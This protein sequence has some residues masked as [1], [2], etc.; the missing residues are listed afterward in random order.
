MTMLAASKGI[1]A[2][3]V[4]GTAWALGFVAFTSDARADDA[5]SSR[6]VESID[7]LP[8]WSLRLTA[9]GGVP[10]PTVQQDLLHEEGYGGLRWAF[11]GSVERRVYESVGIGVM[12]LSG[13]RETDAEPR[14]G[15]E[16]FAD[17]A[18]P[19]RYSERFSIVAFEVPVSLLMRRRSPW[20][21]LEL[22]PWVGVGW[23]KAWLHEAPEWHAAPAFGA[24]VRAMGRGRHGGIGLA[25]GAYSLS[26]A[27]PSVLAG[28]VNFGMISLSLVGGLDAG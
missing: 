8:P 3:F 22:V 24:S 28:A 25:L 18:E 7:D 20:F 2:S 12:G 6:P 9:G 17:N 19:P 27:E 10:V 15:A 14:K 26:V 11:S 13:F 1:R 5:G 23:G 16:R 4:V 21:A